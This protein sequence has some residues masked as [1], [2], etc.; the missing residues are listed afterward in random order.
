LA[1]L[2]DDGDEAGD[3]SGA[4][5][6]DG[7][8]DGDGDGGSHLE[9]TRP[10]KGPLRQ[11]PETCRATSPR[12]I[13]R[14]KKEVVFWRGPRSIQPRQRRSDSGNVNGGRRPHRPLVGTD[15]THSR[16]GNGQRQVP[17][18]EHRRELIGVAADRCCALGNPGNAGDL[19]RS[20]RHCCNHGL[21]VILALQQPKQA[22]SSSKRRRRR[23]VRQ[24]AWHQCRVYQRRTG[25]CS[26]V[27]GWTALVRG[28]A[29]AIRRGCGSHTSA[30]ARQCW[31]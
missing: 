19:R 20:Q 26:G 8:G 31:S 13:T 18:P 7:D 9:V 6:G 3:P 10:C 1:E 23:D 2:G 25:R 27:I 4:R 12:L 29:G 17:T 11:T 21:F 14:A 16:H 30:N 24:P 15:D 5:H 28:T 22:G